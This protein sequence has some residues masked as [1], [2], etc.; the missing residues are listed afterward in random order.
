M[1][2]DTAPNNTQ[3]KIPDIDPCWNRIGV[4][5]DATCPNLPSHNHCRH[6]PTQAGAVSVML[7]RPPPEDYLDEW[8]RH[9][10]Q[11]RTF[12]GT[13]GRG[14]DE[15]AEAGGDLSV[16]I[17]RIGGE[18]LAMPTRVLEEVAEIR[19]V[20]SLPHRRSGVVAGVA[21][22]HGRL[23]ICV[24]LAALL[25]LKAETRPQE[26][27]LVAKRRMLV[28][29]RDPGSFVFAADEVEGIH[30]FKT[31]MLRAAPSNVARAAL[32]YTRWVIPWRDRTIGCLDAELLFD[33]LA[34]GIA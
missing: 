22:I 2:P 4:T 32:S 12:A 3:G 25:N 21:N 16:L 17:F 10:A 29:G 6:C 8:T 9:V 18:W 15:A 33:G 27:S 1:A 14:W 26:R 31:R 19:P 13:S 7:N 28:I 24:S 23:L 5:G 11:G 20:H 30:R 34:R